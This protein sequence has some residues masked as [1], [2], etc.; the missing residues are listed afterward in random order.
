MA[1]GAE[2]RAVG[3]GLFG[4]VVNIGVKLYQGKKALSV[5]SPFSVLGGILRELAAV[6]NLETCMELQGMD[7]ERLRQERA[8][9]Q[10][11][12]EELQRILEEVRQ[13]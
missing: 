6:E 13:Q 12:V 9:L 2:K 3:T 7:V 11:E 1:C 5:A 10:R 4:L 8:R